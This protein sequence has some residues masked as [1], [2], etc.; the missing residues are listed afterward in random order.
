MIAVGLS[1]PPVHH[2]SSASVSFIPSAPLRP[3]QRYAERPRYR[4]RN[5]VSNVN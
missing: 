3:A 1:L 4:C 5:V 2:T